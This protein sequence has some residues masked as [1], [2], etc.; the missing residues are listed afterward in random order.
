ML[1][2]YRIRTRH[3]LTEVE[4]LAFF[5]RFYLRAPL[6]V[7]RA[8]RT[9]ATTAG[10]VIPEGFTAHSENT[11]TILIPSS[12]DAFLNPVQEFNRDL[13]V[14]CISVWSEVLSAEKAAKAAAKTAK[15]PPRKKAKR[16]LSFCESPGASCCK[17]S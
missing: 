16:G 17:C 7:C 3:N 1:F 9:M 4:A 11:T 14:A 15:E 6:S 13:S 5:A 2:G 8:Q 10:L 12:N